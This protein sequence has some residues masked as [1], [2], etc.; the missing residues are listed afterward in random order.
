MMA[1][2]VSLWPLLLN[3]SGFCEFRGVKRWVIR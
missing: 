1:F 2:S 3:C